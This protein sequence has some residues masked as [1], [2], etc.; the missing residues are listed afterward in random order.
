VSGTAHPH[1]R[2]V[3]CHHCGIIKSA[4]GLTNPLKTWQRAE[5]WT[6]RHNLSAKEKRL[7][8]FDFEIKMKLK[9]VV[10]TNFVNNNNR[11][12]KLENNK[13]YCL[14]EDMLNSLQSPTFFGQV[15]H[16]RGVPNN[17]MSG[18]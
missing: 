2:L 4:L 1:N 7:R 11:L 6:E 15:G 16:Y 17:R 18:A 8:V 10:I 14:D 5:I 13:I 9:N 12:Y 3:C